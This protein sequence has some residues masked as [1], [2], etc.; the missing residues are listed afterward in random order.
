MNIQEYFSD[1]RRYWYCDDDIRAEDN[2]DITKCVE[3][4]LKKYKTNQIRTREILNHL[5]SYNYVL[6]IQRD[7]C[8]W[9][10]LCYLVFSDV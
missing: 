9:F 3:Y 6:E 2:T 1:L 8:Y 4:V 10:T 5:V 7:E